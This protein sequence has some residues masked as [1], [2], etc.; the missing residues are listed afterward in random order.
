MLFGSNG[1]IQ[2]AAEA[3]DRDEDQAGESHEGDA[4]TEEPPPEQLPLRDRLG[5]E[6]DVEAELDLAR[7]QDRIGA[8]PSG[9]DRSSGGSVT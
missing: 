7:G 8:R 2:C 3:D 6:A 1:A 5:G 9:T 4:V